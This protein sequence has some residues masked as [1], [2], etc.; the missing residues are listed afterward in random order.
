MI[1]CCLLCRSLLQQLHKLQSLIKGRVVLC[2]SKA[3]STQTG[4]CFMVSCVITATHKK[5]QHCVNQLR[6]ADVSTKKSDFLLES[7][8]RGVIT[9]LWFSHSL[10]R[11]WRYVLSWCWA[12]SRPAFLLSPSLKM[13]K[14]RP[15][16][17]RPLLFH[18]Q[19][20]IPQ[21]GVSCQIRPLATWPWRG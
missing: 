14:A 13:V 20:F 17:L 15:V 3:A 6:N 7:P 16:S 18:Q 11:W 21:V 4:T 5:H 9:V 10:C 12:L 1:Y 8:I 2:S 19:N